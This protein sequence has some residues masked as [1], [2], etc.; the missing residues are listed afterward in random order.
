MPVLVLSSAN[1]I[2]A[3]RAQFPSWAVQG[4]CVMNGVYVATSRSWVEKQFADYLWDFQQARGQQTWQK[5]GNQCEH[6]ALRAALEV[7]N[8]LA[9]MPDGSVPPEVESI[10]IAAC[11]YYKGAGTPAAV[12]HEVNLWFH[13]GAWHAWEP[14][15]RRYFEFTPAE[16]NTVQQIII[17]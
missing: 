5:R 17:P 11:K 7:V 8:L 9:Q 1:L 2:Q 15:T 12:W 6:F 4:P 3:A 10:A 16:L 14:Q 13:D